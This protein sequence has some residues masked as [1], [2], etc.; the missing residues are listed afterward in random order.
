MKACSLTFS[1]CSEDEK[2][3]VSSDRSCA[4]ASAAMATA[5]VAVSIFFS[6]K[7]V[8]ALRTRA[9]PVSSGGMHRRSLD[10]E[11]PPMSRPT[12]LSAYK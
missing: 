2:P 9:S 12:L 5:L 11:G 1:N 8:F 6:S 10:Q 3:L 4:L 7:A